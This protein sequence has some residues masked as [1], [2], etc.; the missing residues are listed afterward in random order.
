MLTVVGKGVVRFI[1]CSVTTLTTTSVITNFYS[2][3]E[4]H[5]NNCEKKT[6]M[7]KF[8]IFTVLIKILPSP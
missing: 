2:Y 3:I 5:N 8:L 7:I 1:S 4:I 6:Y